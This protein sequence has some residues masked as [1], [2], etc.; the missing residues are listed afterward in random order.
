MVFEDDIAEMGETHAEL[1]TQLGRYQQAIGHNMLKISREKRIY[2]T[3][4]L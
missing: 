4:F 2:A 3:C 1:E